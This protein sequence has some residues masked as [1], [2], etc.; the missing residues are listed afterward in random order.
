MPA[1]GVQYP[2]ISR[3]LWDDGDEITCQNG[4]ADTTL[5]PG[6]RFVKV[7]GNTLDGRPVVG[8]PGAGDDSV[9]GVSVADSVA[10]ADPAANQLTVFH[11]RHKIVEVKAGAALTAGEKVMSDATGRAIVWAGAGNVSA[12]IAVF[13]CASGA[14]AAID[15][16]VGAGIV[17]A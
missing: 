7:T 17:H 14:Q 12:G 5:L 4:L 6:S 2:N 1:P 8:F 13:D 11:A 16:S 10:G 15:R 9:F 3:P